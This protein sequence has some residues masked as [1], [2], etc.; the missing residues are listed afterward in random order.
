MKNIDNYEMTDN[1]TYASIEHHADVTSSRDKPYAVTSTSCRS[2]KYCY[3]C[4]LFLFV[5]VVLVIFG[6]I[7][8][9]FYYQFKMASEISQL[10]NAISS[11]QLDNGS[12]GNIIATAI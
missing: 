6:A 5:F 9:L 8:A 4:L 7:S 2:Q 3:L 1:L 10:R 12:S 11:E